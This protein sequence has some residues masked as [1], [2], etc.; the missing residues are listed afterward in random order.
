VRVVPAV[1]AR[2]NGHYV[3]ARVNCASNAKLSP[4]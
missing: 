1:D 3:Q 2:C 4:K